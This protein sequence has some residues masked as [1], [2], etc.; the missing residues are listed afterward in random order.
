MDNHNF[1]F[2][3]VER[4]ATLSRRSV[5]K[6]AFGTGKLGGLVKSLEN[7]SNEVSSFFTKE[8]SEIDLQLVKYCRNFEDYQKAFCSEVDRVNIETINKFK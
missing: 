3:Q 6:A 5:V 1:I 7:G 4:A 8:L 2:A